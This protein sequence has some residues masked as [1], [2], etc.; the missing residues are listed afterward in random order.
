MTPSPF[1]TPVGLPIR[2]SGC[3][4]RPRVLI[5]DDNADVRAM[6]AWCLRASGWM[7]CEADDG[8]EA[9]EALEAFAPD[10]VVMDVRLP[11]VDGLQIVRRIKADAELAHVRVVVCTGVPDSRLEGEAEESGCDAFVRKPCTPDDMRELLE[12]LVADRDVH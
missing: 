7:V 1:A 6:Y 11:I 12:E 2:A 9:Y 3:R 5:V 4:P 8:V 10:A